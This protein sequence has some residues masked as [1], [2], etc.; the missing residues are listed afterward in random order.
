MKIVKGFTDDELKE[1]ASAVEN[2]KATNGKL[3]AVFDTF[4]KKTGR[5]KGSV[6]NFYYG[7]V[8][9]CEKNDALRSEYFVRLPEIS[10]ARAF[11][12][13]ETE[14]LVSAVIEGKNNN[15]SVRRAIIDLAG[16]NEK[17]ALRYQNKYRSLIRN[18]PEKFGPVKAG[19]LDREN[20]NLV[21]PAAVR[22]VKAEI[23]ALV[24]RIASSVKEENASL[25][26]K[27]A[28]LQQ[29]N[30]MLKGLLKKLGKEN[31]P[32]LKVI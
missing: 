11:D 18:F 13:T 7:F 1:L 15:K 24:E 6:R 2:A 31:H 3:S 12:N 16:G 22:R 23:N 32:G 30:L 29:E 4:A 5:A 19:R 20:V 9:E 26:K 28:L 8:K 27:T 21:P 10:K 25:K 17:L 14:K